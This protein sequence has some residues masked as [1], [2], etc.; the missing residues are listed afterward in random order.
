MRDWGGIVFEADE[1]RDLREQVQRCTQG[2]SRLLDDLR[3]EAKSLK[4]DVRAIQPRQATVISL[5][6]SDGGNNKLVFDPFYIQLVRVVDSKGKRLC[7]DAISP[8][9][10]TDALSDRQ[11]NSDGT[12]RTALGFMMA[13]LKVP[14]GRVYLLSHMIP[15]PRTIRET[16]ERVSPSWVQVYREICEW[17]V[18]YE[19]ICQR[20]YGSDTLVVFDGLLRS[21]KFAGTYFRD[22]GLLLKAAI[23]EHRRREKRD[24]FLVG[25]AKHSKVLQRYSLA[26]ELEEILPA[27]EARFVRVPRE[28]ERKA[29]KWGEWAK[30][31]L[32]EDEVGGE[33]AKFVIGQMFFVRFGARTSDPVWS[34]DVME[35]QSEH[36]QRVFGFLVADAAS[37]FPI[38][39]YPLCL[40]KA[41][42]FAAIVDFDQQILQDEVTT[43]IRS[44]LEPD[45][46]RVIDCQALSSD[47]SSR[48]Y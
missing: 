25:I 20:Q 40:Q 6:A 38:P 44:M 39:Y 42:E 33:A 32:D 18:L 19:L 41:H 22:L 2:D 28:L 1:L 13:A 5:V 45:Q 14:D 30:G 36:A 46:R 10:D 23:E 43:A 9:T 47:L 4:P 8:T 16:P 37:G 35:S 27:G 17:A 3:A 12:P 34:V 15:K 31:S 48:R 29:Y 24:I 11:F 7:L 21:K 26:M